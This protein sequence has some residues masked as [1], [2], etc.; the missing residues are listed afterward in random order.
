MPPP[1]PVE[2]QRKIESLYKGGMSLLQIAARLELGRNTV[3]RYLKKAEDKKAG[4]DA[5]QVKPLKADEI[6]RLRYL[7]AGTVRQSP[8]GKCKEVM[9]WLPAQRVVFCNWCGTRWER[10][11]PTRTAR[12]GR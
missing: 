8:C 10:N 7:A 12:L 9:L 6:T 4:K 11:A 5:S 2:K 1:I 3:G